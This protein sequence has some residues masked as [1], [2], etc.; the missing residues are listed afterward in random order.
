MLVEVT[1]ASK[2]IFFF[3][4]KTLLLC[5][6]GTA[7]IV[8]LLAGFPF[9]FTVLSSVDLRLPLVDKQHKMSADAYIC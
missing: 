8:G 9:L 5:C 1:L 3:N 4:I 2:Y 7:G 6:Q